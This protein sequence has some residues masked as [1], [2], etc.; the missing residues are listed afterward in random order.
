MIDS[1]QATA[2]S[3]SLALFM[4]LPKG[5]T[6]SLTQRF[7]SRENRLINLVRSEEKAA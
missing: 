3:A 5:G 4:A 1:S 2:G 7:S 6:Q